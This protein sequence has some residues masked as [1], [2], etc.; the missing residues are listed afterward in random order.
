MI[1]WL[2]QGK[3]ELPRIFMLSESKIAF[4]KRTRACLKDT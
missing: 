1:P 2:R 4:T 3:Y